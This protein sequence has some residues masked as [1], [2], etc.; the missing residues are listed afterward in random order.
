MRAIFLAAV[1]TGLLTAC[2]YKDSEAQSAAAPAPDPGVVAMSAADLVAARRTSFFLSTRAV[3]QAK[4][5]F[6]DGGDLARTRSAARMLSHW[7]NSLP[8]MFPEGSNV[9]GTRAL[10]AVWSDR[11]GFEAKAAA[12]RDAADYLAEKAGEGDREATKAAFL[13]MAG[14]CHACHETYRAE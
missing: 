8:T 2:S 12:Y 5:G 1:A 7:A 14:T 13:V 9:E 11:A 4:E 10:E 6:E 3:A